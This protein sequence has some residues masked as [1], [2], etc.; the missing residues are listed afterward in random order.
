MIITKITVSVLIKNIYFTYFTQLFNNSM[1]YRETIDYLFNSLPV[2]Q[3]IGSA[4]YKANLDNTLALDNHFDH[5][6]RRF[7]TIHVAGT[8]GKG[9]VSHLLASILAEAGYLTGLYTSPHL[10]DFT[11]RIKVNGLP[12]E[13]SFV[14]SFVNSNIKLLEE[15]KPSFFEMTVAMAFEYFA[16]RGVEVAVIETGMGGRLDSTNIITPLVSVITNIGLDH[17]QFLGPDLPSIAAEKAGIIKPGVPVVVGE[18]DKTTKPVFTDKAAGNNSEIFF[19]DTR[20]K[21]KSVETDYYA[22]IAEYDIFR[23]KSKIF[24]RVKIPLPGRYQEKNLVTVMQ[25]LEI[26]G[27][28]LNI[29]DEAIRVGLSDVKKNTSFEGRWQV[30]G[31]E[32]LIICDTAHNSEGLRIVIEQLADTGCRTK[33][34]VLGFVNDKDVRK[35]LGL[36]P[37]DGIYYFTRSSVPRSMGESEIKNTSEEF[38]LKGESFGGVAEAF[39]AALN[40]SDQGDL[41]Y[42]GGSTF[43]VADL[44]DGIAEGSLVV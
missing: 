2:Y 8:N 30:L 36:F 7:K 35:V 14:T 31:S 32:P 17:T 10:R 42:V 22:G 21:V 15:I 12:V 44:L 38:G 20:Y 5:P 26:I 24:E 1:D 3:R 33:R 39:N 29:N 40:D 13:S 4:A 37:S 9:S 16:F 28:E 41:I 43:V 27:N 34:F 19:A 23:D 6:H 25:T 18:T 11:E